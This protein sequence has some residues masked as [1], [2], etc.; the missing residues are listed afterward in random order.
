[1]KKLTPEIEE[2]MKASGKP[3]LRVTLEELNS[4]KI[5]SSEEIRKKLLKKPSQQ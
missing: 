2:K 4:A 1:M 5:V 3:I